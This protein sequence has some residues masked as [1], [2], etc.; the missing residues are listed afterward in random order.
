MFGSRSARGAAARSPRRCFLP[1]R[2]WPEG[3][4]GSLAVYLAQHGAKHLISL[5]RSG[6]GDERS[7]GYVKACAALGCQ[8]YEAFKVDVANLEGIRK[9]FR[10][11]AKPIAG[12][13][14]GSMILRVR[15]ISPSPP[16]LS[17]PNPCDDRHLRDE[18]GVLTNHLNA[19]G[20]AVRNH[21][22]GGIPRGNLLQ[23]PRYMEPH[24]AALD[25]GVNLDFFTMLSSISGV[26]GQKGQANYAAGNVFQDAFVVYRQSLNLNAIT[27]NL[28]AIQDVGYVAN[29]GGMENHLDL[30]QWTPIGEALL[31]KILGVS[32]LQQQAVP[33]SVASSAAQLV[34]GIACPQP[35]DS[36]LLPDSRLP[37]CS[38]LM[39]WRAIR[40]EKKGG[41]DAEREIQAFL[42][43]HRSGTAAGALVAPPI[44]ILN[45]QFVKTLRLSEPIEQAK[46]LATPW[47]G[48]A[49]GGGVQELGP[50]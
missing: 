11:A 30:R 34:T 33:I 38:D 35:S 20:Q 48:L 39:P 49:V 50:S 18:S 3:L 12:G 22:G 17:S 40:P 47:F 46:P 36:T 16:P 9:V 44:E 23:G 37:R 6:Y 26:M 4:C 13:I 15:T 28:G 41:S 7:Q 19:A 10:D 45:R 42:L 5:S 25:Q 27:I 21:D 43:M 2:G 29:Q 31:R 1:H 32:I 8:I 24:Y 14:Q